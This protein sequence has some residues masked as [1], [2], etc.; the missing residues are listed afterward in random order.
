[1]SEKS[2]HH[3]VVERYFNEVLIQGIY[4]SVLSSISS[5]EQTNAYE[6]GVLISELLESEVSAFLSSSFED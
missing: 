5:L 4:Q 3:I 6:N 1:L 2:L